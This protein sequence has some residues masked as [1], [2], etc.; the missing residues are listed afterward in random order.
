MS[1]ILLFKKISNVK[2]LH[3]V[4]GIKGIVEVVWNSTL[5]TT[6]VLVNVH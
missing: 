1:M 6:T 3:H 4:F 2:W 5:V